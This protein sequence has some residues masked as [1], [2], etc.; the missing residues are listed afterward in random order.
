ML[1]KKALLKF[2]GGLASL[3]QYNLS[4]KKNDQ[5]KESSILTFNYLD[6]LSKDLIT[7]HRSKIVFA[8]IC[9]LSSWLLEWTSDR[10]AVLVMLL[11]WTTNWAVVRIAKHLNL[12]LFD[13][14]LI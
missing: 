2:W 7:A 5:L 6:W 11:G 10:A 3:T 9:G 13:L 12:I 14:N 4:M 1:K 8:N